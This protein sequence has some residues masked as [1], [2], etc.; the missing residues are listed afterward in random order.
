MNSLHWKIATPVL[1]TASVMLVVAWRTSPQIP[2]STS[3]QAVTTYH[4]D[5]LRTGWNSNETVLT[6]GNVN[7]TSFGLLHSVTLDEQVDAQPLI[8]PGVNIT[9]GQHQGKHDVVYVATEKNTIYAIDAATGLVLLSPNLGPAVPK[10]ENCGNNSVV[11]GINGTPVIDHASNSMYVI[12]YTLGNPNTGFSSPAAPTYTIHE[13]DLGNLKDKLTPV[14]V[15]ASHKLDNGSTYKFNATRQRQRPGLLDA[16]GNIYAGFGSFCDFNPK[17]TRGWVLGWQKG[18]LTQL[19]DN[20]L[21]DTQIEP[22]P[23]PL[24]TP[25]PCPIVTHTPPESC[26]FLSSVWMSGYG[27]ASDSSG[28]VYFVTGNSDRYHDTYDG[29][30]DVQE[31]VV[32]LTSSL[33]MSDIF[34]PGDH[35]ALDKADRDYGSGGV[36]L[37]PPQAGS[38]PHLAA[39]AGKEGNLF[40][41]N[42]ADLGGSSSTNAGIVGEVSIGKCWCGQSYFSSGVPHV[43][44]S[45][46]TSVIL[47]KLETSPSV[48]LVS[49]GSLT[50][51]SGQDP[52]FFTSISSSG[53]S[54]AII[55][56]VSRPTFALLPNGTRDTRVFLHAI[57]PQPSNG[58]L[59]L[60]LKQAAGTWTH[61]GGNANIVPVVANGHVYVASDKRLSIF[62]LLPAGAVSETITPDPPAQT[63]FIDTTQHEIFG[64]ISSINGSQFTLQTRTGSLVNVDAS[65][66]IQNDLSIG[67]EV[68]GAV[69]VQG[70][71]DASGVLLASSI[72]R[73]KDSP[74]LWPSDI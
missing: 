8:V 63:A 9:A 55:W 48:K 53:S 15:A 37:L 62:G 2:A 14:V 30:T 56:A 1:V 3:P 46:G 57:N 10:P 26:Y 64:T 19:A 73:A 17:S 60:L 18:T 43:V 11:V 35:F 28:N 71:I 4:N 24:P 47:W 6:P 68:G 65:V 58:S 25:T 22:P 44:S 7:G 52:G 20:K 42:Q 12:V 50:I 49:E 59:P 36:L 41:L 34:T 32:K 54:N 40:L 70:T 21:T 72:Q 23:A 29:V 27:L 13:L 33:T 74:D 38:I 5:N 66:A 51:T 69:D 16:N 39:A 31:S 61:G 67:L 45:G